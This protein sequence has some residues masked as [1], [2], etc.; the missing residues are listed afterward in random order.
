MSYQYSPYNSKIK[1]KRTEN[2]SVRKMRAED[3]NCVAKV[4]FSR[5]KESLEKIT[6]NLQQEYISDDERMQR[7]LFVAE[8]D[9]VI[10]GFS[11]LINF[12]YFTKTLK[13]TPG[14]YLMAVVVLPSFQRLG[15]GEQLTNIRIKFCRELT[16]ELFYF[17]NVQ[18]LA[19][20]RMHESYGFKEVERNSS[21]LGISMD[22]GEGIL[23]KL[24]LKSLI[25]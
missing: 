6:I 25:I 24:N 20:I 1:S 3:I 11:R 17:A 14:Y 21:F 23:Y 18:N 12:K 10:V 5:G 16:N 15:I 13:A 4:I 7:Q 2:V 8:I 19:S 9:N 22:D